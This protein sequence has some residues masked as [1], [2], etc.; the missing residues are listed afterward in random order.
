LFVGLGLAFQ[1]YKTRLRLLT[2]KHK[3]YEARMPGMP[4]ILVLPVIG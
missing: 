4:G 3:V 2:L 1:I